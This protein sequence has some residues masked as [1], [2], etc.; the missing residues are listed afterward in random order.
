MR[1]GA[2]GV[3]LAAMHAALLAAGCALDGPIK[4]DVPPRVVRPERSA[5]V[6]FT[7][8]LDAGVL[9]EMLAAGELPN[10][11]RRFVRGGVRVRN[12]IASMPSN[13]YPNT[14]SLVTGVFPGRHGIVGNRWFDRHALATE[15]YIRADTFRNVNQQFLA[16][17][18]FERLADRLTL[19]VQLHTRRGASV[20][21]EDD[22]RMALRWMTGDYVGHDRQTGDYAAQIDDVAR[23]AGRWPALTVF[24]FPGIDEL[25][26]RFSTDSRQYRDAVRN[27]DV[28]I[29]R[30]VSAWEQAG[31]LENTYWVLVSDHGHVAYGA[32]EYLDVAGWFRRTHALRVSQE[33]APA[34]DYARRYAAFAPYD[35]YVANGSFRG[36]AIHVRG[37]DGWHTS[38]PLERLRALL[39]PEG[40]TGALSDPA[41]LFAQRGVELAV[42]SAG[43]DRVEVYSRH[44]R[45]VVEA[46]SAEAG[47]GSGL[48]Y[49]LINEVGDAL[50][51]GQ[52]AEQ[53]AFVEA[54]WHDSQ[55]WLTATAELRV[56]D[57]VPQ[58]VEMFRSRRSGDIVLFASE[59]GT[60]QNDE[61]SGHGSC[62]ASDM[63][64]TL[65]FA[66]PD[67]PGGCEIGAARMVDVTPTLLELLQAGIEDLGVR[68]DGRSIAPQLKHAA[69]MPS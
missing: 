34:G 22:L 4:L 8:G 60:F 52:T 36:S 33:D 50:G 53:R 3:A 56:P 12:A 64:I 10:V 39:W 7:D 67:L 45:A 23:S 11:A 55:A 54:G 2:V 27:A 48:R 62:L 26:H 14:V 40:A 15:Y 17:T 30:I 28:Q 24:Y 68:I 59:R 43:A 38:P 46:E 69:E 44:G 58:V 51:Y 35:A 6:L 25:G 66:G 21:L 61:R 9:D 63:R 32:D 16:P 29:G 41:A 37:P 13:T 31:L 1:A 18:I 42:V 57:F 19:A 65:F 49:R 5:V 47:G 20:V